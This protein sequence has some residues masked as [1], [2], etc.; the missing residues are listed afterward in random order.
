MKPQIDPHSDTWKAIKARA[1]ERLNTLRL[2]NDAFGL[3]PNGTAVIRGRIAELKE[4]LALEK[5]PDNSADDS[6]PMF[7]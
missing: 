2:Q 1:D 6:E 7:Y 5:A 3:D 4:L